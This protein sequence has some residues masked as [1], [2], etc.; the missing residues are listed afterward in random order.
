MNVETGG[1]AAIGTVGA[2][3]GTSM[4]SSFAEGSMGAIGGMQGMKGIPTGFAEIG[5]MTPSFSPDSISDFDGIHQPL[6]NTD[7]FNTLFPAEP[8]LA[9]QSPLD[10]L[11]VRPFAQFDSKIAVLDTPYNILNEVSDLLAFANEADEV[12]VESPELT[13]TLVGEEIATDKVLADNILHSYLDILPGQTL[14]ALVDTAVEQKK[15]HESALEPAAKTAT[16]IDTESETNISDKSM[17]ETEIVEPPFQFVEVAQT[18]SDPVVEN[19]ADTRTT[20]S[21]V[22]DQ[23]TA[24]AEEALLHSSVIDQVIAEEVTAEVEAESTLVSVSPETVQKISAQVETEVENQPETQFTTD[25]RELVWENVQQLAREQSTAET[26]TQTA[27]QTDTVTITEQN[28]EREVAISSQPA[29]EEET[30]IDKEREID[31]AKR[32]ESEFIKDEITNEIRVEKATAV[33]EAAMLKKAEEQ[34][35]AGVDIE[36][37]ELSGTELIDPVLT[38][39]PQAVED[40]SDIVKNAPIDD[41]TI[42]YIDEQ[43]SATVFH[44]GEVEDTLTKII[45][46]NTAVSVGKGKTV[47]EKEVQKVVRKGKI[48]LKGIIYSNA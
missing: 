44:P 30:V 8:I 27:V 28:T 19:L 20:V 40:K 35:S 47:G 23:D 29:T 48:A 25:V 5:D 14:E 43:A 31:K 39:S 3:T 1:M 22:V 4:G 11:T 33:V 10:F 32:G 45:E 26:E 21:S 16:A 2:S 24:P 9:V 38:P 37:L 15:Y 13:Q 46:E 6:G 36:D 18:E 34:H 17:S 42:L 41:Q 12:A 7:N